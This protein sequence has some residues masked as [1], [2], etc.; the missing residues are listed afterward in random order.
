VRGLLCHRCN[1]TVATWMDER[2]CMRAAWYLRP[3]LP[4]PGGR[5]RTILDEINGIG[6]GGES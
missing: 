2:W 5:A 4:Q 6:Q 3:E 1:R